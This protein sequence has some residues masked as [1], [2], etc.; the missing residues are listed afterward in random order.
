MIVGLSLHRDHMRSVSGTGTGRW[1]VKGGDWGG[2]A[3]DGGDRVD[4]GGGVK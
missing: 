2:G 4:G 1:G 3:L